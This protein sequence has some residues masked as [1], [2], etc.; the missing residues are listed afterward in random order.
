MMQIAQRCILIFGMCIMVG[1]IATIF[2]NERKNTL[3]KDWETVQTERFIDKIC[4]T[5]KCSL[6]EYSL[7]VEALSCSGNKVGIRIEEYRT[8]QDLS[9][10]RYYPMASWEEIKTFLSEE[11]RYVF[12]ENSFVLLEITQRGRWGGWVIGEESNDT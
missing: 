7:F 6:E 3:T 11:G 5:G 10:K 8:E 2:F 12:S 4:R 1:F 9:K